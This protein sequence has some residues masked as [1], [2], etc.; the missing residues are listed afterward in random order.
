MRPEHFVIDGSNLATEG[1]TEPSLA[2][3]HEAIEAI[4]AEHPEAILT[5][6]VDASFEHR[7]DQSEAK[8]FERIKSAGTFVSPP[9]GAVGRGDGF[10]LQIA[11]RTGATVLSNDSFQEFHGE[12]EW[13]FDTGR[14]IGGKPVPGVGWIFSIRRPVRGVTSRKAV[15]VKKKDGDAADGKARR[16]VKQAIAEATADVMEPQA[17]RSKRRRPR[18]G[19]QPAEPIND[20]GTFLKFVIDYRPGAEVEGTIDTFASHGAFVLVGD[21]RCYAPL[22]GLGNPPPTRARDVLAQ[23]EVRT[24]VVQAIDAPRRGIELS[25][26]EFA[27]PAAAPS[28]ETVAAETTSQKSQRGAKKAPAKKRAATKATGKPLAKKTAPGKT[29]ANKT[30]TI[31]SATTKTAANKT[32]ANKTPAKKVVAKKIAKR[33]VAVKAPAA[34]SVAKKA[35]AGTQV[36]KKAAK[37][38]P[39]KKVVT[40]KVVTK[41]AVAKKVVAKKAPAKKVAPRVAERKTTKGKR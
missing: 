32:A 10:L 27:V 5:I 18:R 9:A 26:P 24:F 40:K 30:P 17:T 37:K 41:K 31:K 22:V 4:K 28:D 2:Q 34:K 11:H 39:V 33:V 3:L 6:V 13:L 25:L 29:P 20:P 21:V 7:I 15:A 19:Q 16:E 35:A 8:E 1:R 14:L 36:A 38:A 12:Y 23:G